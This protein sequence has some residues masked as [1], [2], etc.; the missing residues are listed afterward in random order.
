MARSGEP[1]EPPSAGRWEVG[2]ARRWRRLRDEVPSR[3]MHDPTA[4]FAGALLWTGWLTV[5]VG[6]VHPGVRHHELRPETAGENPENP[7]RWWPLPRHG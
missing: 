2:L 5:T 4:V 1:L 6:G 7:A 3:S